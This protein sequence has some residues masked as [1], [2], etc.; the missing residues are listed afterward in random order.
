MLR[1]SFA[2]HW[3]PEQ[4]LKSG[5]WEVLLPVKSLRKSL[6]AIH[7][8][9]GKSCL[10]AT[11]RLE[12][13]NP[14]VMAQSFDQLQRLAPTTDGSNFWRPESL[15]GSYTKDQRPADILEAT[16]LG[17]WLVVASQ[18]WLSKLW[19]SILC[20]LVTLTHSLL[21]RASTLICRILQSCF[22]KFILCREKEFHTDLVGVKLGGGRPGWPRTTMFRTKKDVDKHVQVGSDTACMLQ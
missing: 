14:G 18:Q 12:F 8:D 21:R 13:N 20:G 16:N 5:R 10:P 3:E 9:P 17:V 2:L 15:L 6:R 11:K 22:A 19:K 1:F 4:G 7:L